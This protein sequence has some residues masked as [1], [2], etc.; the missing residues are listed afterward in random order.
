MNTF[1]M[2]YLLCLFV[3]SILNVTSLQFVYRP[4]DLTLLGLYKFV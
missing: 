3:I 1:L 4:I 2:A